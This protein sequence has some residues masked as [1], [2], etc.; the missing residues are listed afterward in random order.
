[1]PAYLVRTI[2]DHDIVGF[3]VA[4]EMD[5]LL[6]AVDECTEPEDCEYVELPAGGILWSSPAIAVPFDPGDVEDKNADDDQELPWAKAELSETWWNV[7]YGY[8][9]DKWTPFFP[10]QPRKPR[11]TAPPR[12]MGPGRVVPYRKRT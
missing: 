9:D 10:D 5:D 12:P 2:D 11:P 1:M 7:V 8:S 6:I 4:D 3:F